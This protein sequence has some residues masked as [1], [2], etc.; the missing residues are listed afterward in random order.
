MGIHGPSTYGLV[1]A[2]VAR[3][4]AGTYSDRLNTWL[5]N[6][7]SSGGSGIST[8]GVHSQFPPSSGDGYQPAT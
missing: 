2:G 4:F 6:A 8:Y 1:E 7:V 5:V 3:D